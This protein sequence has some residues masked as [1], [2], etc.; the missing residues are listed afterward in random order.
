MAE[1]AQYSPSVRGHLSLPGIH[2][3]ITG[4]DPAP[5]RIHPLKDAGTYHTQR[6][7]SCR[8][9]RTALAL[10]SASIAVTLL[11][12]RPWTG[13]GMEPECADLFRKIEDVRHG[14]QP[15]DTDRDCTV[16]MNGHYWNGC[17]EEVNRNNSRKLDGMKRSYED[18]GCRA[19]T[20]GNC[21]PRLIRGCIRGRCGG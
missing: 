4:N 8:P 21:A 9:A 6:S 20:D 17:P 16:W 15:C 5:P 7:I 3:R 13:T 1:G 12:C 2:S 18:R 14:P 10:L 19:E 11:S